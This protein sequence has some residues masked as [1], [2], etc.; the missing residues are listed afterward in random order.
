MCRSEVPAERLSERWAR[1]ATVGASTARVV[2]ADGQDPRVRAAA[3]HLTELGVQTFLIGDPGADLH[4]AVVARPAGSPDREAEDVL[5]DVAV[6]R[7][8]DTARRATCLGDPVFRAAALVRAGVADAAVAGAA[9]P[10]SVVIRAGI[11]VIGLARPGGLLSSCFLMQLPQGT[12]LAFGDCAVVPE[13]D[14]SQLAEIAISTAQ[15]F[16]ELSG[17][18]PAVALLS[19]STAGSATHPA[20]DRV[21]RATTLVTQRAPG[22]RVD[23]ELQFDAAFVPEVARSKAPDSV[24]AGRANV[25]IFPDLAAGNIGYKIAQRIGGAAAYGPILQGLAAPMNDVS[26]GCDVQDVVNVALVS[27]LQA[28]PAGKPAEPQPVW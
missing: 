2:L 11:Q 26:R 27:V 17:E 7:G 19:F 9:A 5:H 1:E 8:W 24:L 6:D 16:G 21:R 12:V 28:R 23:G 20:V 13:P 25:L 22:L 10:S 15:T 4:P 3:G 14:E 18:D